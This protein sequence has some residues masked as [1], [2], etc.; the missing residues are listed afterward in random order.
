MFK[1]KEEIAPAISR[2]LFTPKPEN[3]YNIRSRGKPIEPFYRK[4]HTKFNIDY[5]GSHLWN[6]LAHDNF[7]AL[8]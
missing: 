2:N 4:K 3:K 7:R 8:D 1:R 5:R 6:K